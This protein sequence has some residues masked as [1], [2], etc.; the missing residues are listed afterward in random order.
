[1]KAEENNIE[2]A[3][4]LGDSCIETYLGEVTAKQFRKDIEDLKKRYT[5]KEAIQQAIN[6]LQQLI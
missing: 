4:I 2:Q 1:M 6:Q 3:L 5:D